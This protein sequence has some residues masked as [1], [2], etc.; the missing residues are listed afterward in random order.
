MDAVAEIR[1]VAVSKAQQRLRN[2]DANF[3]GGLHTS[4]RDGDR[5]F[6]VEIVLD[7]A[8]RVHV[9]ASEEE[10]YESKSHVLF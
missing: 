7:K 1:S 3:S 6:T 5:H 4:R 2:T 10:V 8:Y 9:H